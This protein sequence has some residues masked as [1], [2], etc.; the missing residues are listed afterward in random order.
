MDTEIEAIKDARWDF[1]TEADTFTVRITR[2]QALELL[3]NLSHSKAQP[4]FLGNSPFGLTGNF[5]EMLGKM[6]IEGTAKRKAWD[7]AHPIFPPEIKINPP[8][9]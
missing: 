7:E 8:V 6:T 1:D 5:R 9:V 2:R 3:D 4:H